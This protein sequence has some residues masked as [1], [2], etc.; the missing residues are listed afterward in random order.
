VGRSGE[1]GGEG[2]G[3]ERVQSGCN[4]RLDANSV[5]GEGGM[6]IVCMYV[7]KIWEGRHTAA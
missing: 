1:G 7:C 6:Y 2:G 4:R 5:Q 3:G